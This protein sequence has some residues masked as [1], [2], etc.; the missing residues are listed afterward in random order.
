MARLWD[1]GKSLDQRILEF[2]AGEDHRLDERLVPYDVSASVA[3]A[4]MLEQQGLLAAAESIPPAY[5]DPEIGRVPVDFLST[6]DITGGN[7]GS[8]TLNA[9]GEIVG[10]AFDGNLEGVISDYLFDPD[11]VRTIQVDATY[12]RFVMDEVD[13]AHALLREMGLP[14]FTEP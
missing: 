11:V 4:R 14:V 7:S 6:C 3:H 8:P 9:R 2:T 1:K 5:L 13:H 12:L 10:L